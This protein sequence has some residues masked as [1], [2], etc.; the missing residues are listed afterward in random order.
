MNDHPRYAK[1][2]NR[3]E[4]KIKQLEKLAACGIIPIWNI[5]PHLYHIGDRKPR[6]A[7]SL[8]FLRKI[9]YN[10]RIKI[11]YANYTYRRSRQ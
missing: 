7:L 10:E 9:C 8:A 3:G 2:I 5:C 1:I 11:S 4:G 6:K